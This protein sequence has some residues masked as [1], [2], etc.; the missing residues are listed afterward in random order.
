M[1]QRDGELY[2]VTFAV[3][4]VL[5]VIAV[6]RTPGL[7]FDYRLRWTWAVGM[8][9]FIAIVWCTA[10]AVERRRGPA[11]RM[12]VPAI[13][14]V[15][16][17]A[18]TTINVTTAAT[19]DVPQAA[20]TKVVVALIPGLLRTLETDPSGKHGQVFVDD[21][22]L[23]ISAWYS[24]SLVLQLE[25]HGYDARME[26]PRGVFL[27]DH[28]QLDD[29]HVG[30]HLVVASDDEIE[31]RD[32]DPS[33]HLIA[34]W[35]S[36]TVEQQLAHKARAAA[37]DQDLA[38]GRIDDAHHALAMLQIGLGNDNPAVAWAVAVYRADV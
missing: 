32:A 18:C 14:L 4:F 3:A 35:S 7:A 11:A 33:L 1:R 30:V 29:A 34:K 31:A 15:G 27:G 25:R 16:L 37:L 38:A 2:L 22:P 5:G 6:Q 21:G 17:L 13:A 8:I 12:V 20:D 19:A 28:R 36:V 26:A 24:R 23:Q 9:G 10:V